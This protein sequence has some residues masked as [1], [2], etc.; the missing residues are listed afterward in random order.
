[1]KTH[2]LIFRNSVVLMVETQFE[3]VS[4]Y[5]NDLATTQDKR[6]IKDRK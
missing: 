2:V 4:L 5:F 1:M 3:C 6:A